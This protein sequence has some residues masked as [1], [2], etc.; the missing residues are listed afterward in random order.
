M[1]K[2]LTYKNLTQ[3]A[4]LQ[5]AREFIEAQAQESEL[6]PEELEAAA[7]GSDLVVTASIV[8]GVLTAASAGVIGWAVADSEC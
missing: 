4:S 6:T 3:S 7:G 1:S 8:Y 2:F 5:E